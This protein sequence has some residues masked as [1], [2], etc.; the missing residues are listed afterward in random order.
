M[1][2][3]DEKKGI[4]TKKQSNNLYPLAYIVVFFSFSLFDAT[5]KW[6]AFS[7]QWEFHFSFFSFVF[8]PNPYIAFSLPILS[9][10]LLL[11]IHAIILTIF[12][13]CL[14]KGL[15]SQIEVNIIGFTSLFFGAFNNFID[16]FRVQHVIG[17]ADFIGVAGPTNQALV[18]FILWGALHGWLVY[19]GMDW[20]YNQAK[21]D[22]KAG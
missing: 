4:M 15:Q 6:L 8:T 3:S 22:V 9:G 17:T 10:T 7:Q 14:Y 19:K 16:A 18:Y 1:G 11:L 12:G 2:A 5:L 20:F 13:I 21:Q